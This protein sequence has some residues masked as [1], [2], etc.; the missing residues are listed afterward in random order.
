MK[1]MAFSDVAFGLLSGPLAIYLVRL[2]LT[3]IRQPSKYQAMAARSGHFLAPWLAMPSREPL[4]RIMGALPIVIGC[5][6]TL[7]FVLTVLSLV[8]SLVPNL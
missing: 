1:A 8:L 4:V 3:M 5:I 6:S 2:G 7:L